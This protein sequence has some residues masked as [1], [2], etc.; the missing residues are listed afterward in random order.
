MRLCRARGSTAIFHRFSEMS[1]VIPPA[2][3]I[4]GHPG[5]EI[6]YPIA[7]VEFEDGQVTEVMANDVLFTD[8]LEVMRELEEA[9]N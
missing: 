5:G 8:T 3:M 9:E 4:G 1:Q 7:V 2:I 6:R